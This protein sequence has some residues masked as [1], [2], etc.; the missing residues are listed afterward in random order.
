LNDI[1]ERKVRELISPDI[2]LD[3]NIRLAWCLLSASEKRLRYLRT[4][5]IVWWAI[6]L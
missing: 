6:N 4:G 5:V 3:K 1:D 2:S